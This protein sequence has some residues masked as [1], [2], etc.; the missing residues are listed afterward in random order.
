[1]KKEC[2]KCHTTENITKHHLHQPNDGT[3][4]FLCQSCHDKE[5]GIE[6]NEDVN[7]LKRRI[8]RAK[9][10]I[11]RDT[12]IIKEAEEKIPFK[13]DRKSPYKRKDGYKNIIQFDQ[14]GYPSCEE[15]GA[16]ACV[17]K[18]RSLWRC[19]Q[20]GVG[21]SF[22]DVRVFDEWL[23]RNKQ[24]TDLGIERVGLDGDR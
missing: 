4:L 14:S 22:G 11:N 23:R 16:M 17:N 19:I 5:H 3:I 21:V 18:D 9:R 15:H 20:C 8:K 24:R 2:E 12:K 6:R 13:M 7:S 10:R 1:M